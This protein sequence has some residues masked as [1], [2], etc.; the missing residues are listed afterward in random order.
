LLNYD[1]TKGFP[2]ALTHTR[3]SGATVVD[4]SGNVVWA[5]E[6]LVY[7]LDFS[8]WSNVRSSDSDSGETTPS[9]HI[10][11]KVIPDT[12]T[13]NHRIDEAAVA[14]SANVDVIVSI[15]AKADEYSGVGLSLH[16]ASGFLTAFDLSDGTVGVENGGSGT[17][18]DLGD[19][20]Y[21]CSVVVSARV[22]T[23]LYISV[24]SDGETFSFTGDGSS[25]ILIAKAQVSRGA[26]LHDFLDGDYTPR[27][28]H[29]KDGNA[30]GYLHEPQGTNLQ[31][32]S[33][34][35]TAN[36]GETQLVIGENASVS[37]SGA[38]DASDIIAGTLSTAAHFTTRSYAAPSADTVIA[39]SL[40][41]KA[42]A[43]NFLR[44][45]IDSS[46]R[47][48]SVFNLTDGSIVSTGSRHVSSYAEDV[49]NGWWRCV[50]V[51]TTD[52]VSGNFIAYA[53]D[54]LN[55]TTAWAG[56]GSATSISVWGAQVEEGTAATSLIP[57]FGAEATRQA[58]AVTAPEMLTVLAGWPDVTFLLEGT[59]LTGTAGA[60]FLKVSNTD[61]DRV[62]FGVTGVA[63]QGMR[64]FMSSSA[65]GFANH[66]RETLASGDTFKIATTVVP[67][68]VAACLNGGSLA[69]DVSFERI[70]VNPTA[71][72]VGPGGGYIYERIR[73]YSGRLPDA[74][75]ITLTT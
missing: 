9:G 38:T 13:N 31:S 33:I 6:N 14:E 28:T 71:A 42:G 26:V 12:S 59:F 47:A 75:L 35:D 5:D 63:G 50:L 65:G 36:W 21:R 58:D 48:K 68:D 74:K 41:A 73:I 16:A 66:I 4:E 44:L 46:G 25:G 61:A 10:S 37:P 40:Y 60:I 15:E 19:G 8:S 7:D 39:M 2:A 24:G 72:I 52:G 18:K 49:G 70:P 17:I 67:D 11:S 53:H 1:F 51:G 20:W 22:S 54:D 32:V 30:L 27:I 45:A 64:T 34:P 57:T 56:D 23:R 55:G 43:V 29:D 62:Q 69:T 3:A